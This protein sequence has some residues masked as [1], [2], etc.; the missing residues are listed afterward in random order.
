MASPI[1]ALHITIC[2]KCHQPFGYADLDREDVFCPNGHHT[3]ATGGSL[4]QA[5]HVWHDVFPHVRTKKEKRETIALLRQVAL[6]QITVPELVQAIEISESGNKKLK[7]LAKAAV[8]ASIAGSM[9]VAQDA[10]TRLAASG[11]DPQAPAKLQAS[12]LDTLDQIEDAG[13]Y[14]LYVGEPAEVL[15]PRKKSPRSP[16][17]QARNQ[18]QG[19]TETSSASKPKP[20]KVRR[21]KEKRS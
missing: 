16:A 7:S 13:E 5:L 14:E 21:A 2:P 10:A 15:A 6:G 8:A 9:G 17:S 11:G 3:A 19:Q 1:F 4:N 18:G 12:L 20:P